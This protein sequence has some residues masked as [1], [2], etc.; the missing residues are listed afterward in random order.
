M[1]DAVGPFTI[2][3][4]VL[5][6]IGIPFS[7][8]PIIVTFKKS[9]VP[10][11]LF[12]IYLSIV[13]TSGCLVVMAIESMVNKE[14]GF[15][16]GKIA[17]IICQMFAFII[18]ISNA[19]TFAL[20]AVERYLTVVKQI[21]LSRKSI[22]KIILGIFVG[23]TCL[24][25]LPS[26][27]TPGVVLPEESQIQCTPAFWLK[28]P[29]ATFIFTLIMI[30]QTVS[31]TVLVYCYYQI[32]NKINQAIKM[33]SAQHAGMQMREKSVV[34]SSYI[35]LI[36]YEYTTGEDVSPV[37]DFITFV[38]VVI[39]FPAT[40]LVTIFLDFRFY[41]LFCE[42]FGIKQRKSADLEPK[43]VH[44]NISRWK[45]TGEVGQCTFDQKP[46]PRKDEKTTALLQ[47]LESIE[48]ALMAVKQDGVIMQKSGAIIQNLSEAFEESSFMI[49]ND[50]RYQKQLEHNEV[51]KAASNASFS[52]N[53]D[54]T[55]N[56]PHL[57]FP[58]S[59]NWELSENL[60]KTMMFHAVFYSKHPN[61]IPGNPVPS[62]YE[63]LAYARRYQYNYEIGALIPNK[64]HSSKQIIADIL[65]LVVEA[66][67][68]FTI[69][70]RPAGI[71]ALNPVIF[72]NRFEKRH[73]TIDDISS[74]PTQEDL[75]SPNS[76]MNDAD[77]AQ[78][79]TVL[80][81]L[82]HVDT[83]NSISSKDAFIL[84]ESLF[85]DNPTWNTNTVPSPPVPIQ[86]NFKDY[87][88][89]SIWENGQFDHMFSE[90]KY[91]SLSEMD[92]PND[93]FS[94]SFFQVRY[95]KLLRKI[96]RF[97]RSINFGNVRENSEKALNLHQEV[98]IFIENHM[99]RS[100]FVF[101]P[102]TG[103][104][105][106]PNVH[107]TGCLDLLSLLHLSAAQINPSLLFSLE[108]NQPCVYTSRDILYAC[109]KRL[110]DMVDQAHSYII[111]G[112]AFSIRMDSGIPSPLFCSTTLSNLTF[113]ISTICLNVFQ[114]PPVDIILLKSVLKIVKD[115]MCPM[116]MQM[117]AVWPVSNRYS[118]YLKDLLQLMETNNQYS[119]QV[120]Q[121]PMT[122]DNNPACTYAAPPLSRFVWTNGRKDDKVD[123]LLEKLDMIEAALIAVKSDDKV[124]EKNGRDIDALCDAFQEAAKIISSSRKNQVVVASQTT[125][126]GL[127]AKYN[128]EIFNPGFNQ[129]RITEGLNDTPSP[130][131]STLTETDIINFQNAFQSSMDTFFTKIPQ[132]TVG[133]E[134]ASH[135]L[136]LSYV[137]FA[138]GNA[139]A[140]AYNDIVVCR[141]MDLSENLKKILMFQAI[142]YSKHPNLIPG[143]PNPTFEDRKMLARQFDYDF[144]ARGT[145]NEI[146]TTM[147][148]IDDIRAI[149]LHAVNMFS[150]QEKNEGMKAMT[151]AFSL[152]KSNKILDASIFQ[153]QFQ[154]NIM[155]IDS[156]TSYRA[157]P[158]VL[159]MTE[160][161]RIQRVS[162]LALF[163][164]LD[165]YSSIATGQGFLLDESLFPEAPI[166]NGKFT[167]YNKF[168]KNK[169]NFALNSIWENTVYDNVFNQMKIDAI[170]KLE[171]AQ[172]SFFTSITQI[173]FIKLMRD[174]IRF[175]RST[176]FNSVQENSEKGVQLHEFILR[177][178]LTITPPVELES[179]MF[180]GSYP[181]RYYPNPHFSPCL[182]LFTLLHFSIAQFNPLLL[183]SLQLGQPCAYT[184]KDIIF[185]CLN[186]QKHVIDMAHFPNILPTPA[187]VGF[188]LNNEI[189]SPLF[190]SST[191][192]NLTFTITSIALSVFQMAPVDLQRLSQVVSMI[193]SS[194]YPAMRRIGMIWP[195]ANDLSR[196]LEGL[197]HIAESSIS[198]NS[199]V[200]CIP[201][202]LL[203]MDKQ[204][205]V[206]S[207]AEF[208]IFRNPAFPE[209]SLRVKYPKLCDPTV[210]QISGY[211]D[212][213][214]DRHVFVFSCKYYFWFFESRDKP[215]SDPVVLWLNGGPGCSSFTG[216]LMEL[217][218]CRVE[219]GGKDTFIHPNSW[220]SN[221]N[222][223]F[224]D[225]PVG[226]GF[227][228]S[229][230]H[231]DSTTEEISQD[232]LV[233]LQTF[234]Y[235]FK[236]YSAL[237]FHITGESYAGHYIPG[238]AKA[239]Y[240]SNKQI[241]AST[242]KKADGY[243]NL[244]SLAIGNGI[245]D[246]IIQYGKYADF[247]EDKKYGPIFSKKT[248]KKMRK[249]YPFCKQL[250]DACYHFQS[251][252]TCVPATQYCNDHITSYFEKTGLNDYDIRLPPGDTTFDDMGHDLN[253]WL[254]NPTIQAELGVNI[255][256]RI[257][258]SDKVGHMFDLQGDE[259]HNLAKDIPTLLEDGIRILIYAGDADWIC[260]WI[261]N[262][263]WT[264]ELEWNGKSEFNEARDIMWKSELTGKKAGEY[265]RFGNFAFLRVYESSHFVPLDQVN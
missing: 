249:A 208:S 80:V 225:Q 11:M 13:N 215:Q 8:L 252:Y 124:M 227:S 2:T 168:R 170:T 241:L 188:E 240:D 102:G 138:G 127:L 181:Q 69:L 79:L 31:I 4:I 156:I 139:N 245:T 214:D 104:T 101:P 54:S 42:H 32:W 10:N 183:F 76:F 94:R 25:A 228:Y 41:S 53:S 78:R 96:I 251:N 100:S 247:G 18:C 191:V 201:N 73:L 134:I 197:I 39:C 196:Q 128:A 37:F 117:G 9:V 143:N 21:T 99:P 256:N 164:N 122:F 167:P 254:N 22:L 233:F 150:I 6:A 132:I 192:C 259:M 265:R 20:I 82:L 157:Q 133:K 47:K 49:K 52:P 40:S 230:S 29:C 226:V 248:V 238:I 59:K 158:P 14:N 74:L 206:S 229:D 105:L 108:A 242:G 173:R 116:F 190:C 92:D 220:N 194:I 112:Q 91:K 106:P 70:D 175:S 211:V 34:K 119:P 60:R 244:V 179:Y 62:F 110:K 28:S 24:A 261:G 209:Y 176:K 180:F 65:A 35:T 16:M 142:F 84:D 257:G 107:M 89:F 161:E 71:R 263:A 137:L 255:K 26:L 103:P 250:I 46:I 120:S 198:A 216:L 186:G 146:L 144:E 85:P 38:C 218:P 51:K 258:C 202:Q 15:A 98:L 3:L 7:A 239:I 185:A 12:P 210:K 237:G 160:N 118:L 174:I 193:N 212:I 109:L 45:K 75:L 64:A 36:L 234:F 207:L 81:S 30:L 219:K 63:K 27:C 155:T 221:A 140:N 217:G 182:A 130:S 177:H 19:Y 204:N 43:A 260:N 77:K 169:S 178:L 86:K 243:V 135:L 149:L 123:S 166:Y 67:N 162:L 205:T 125:P 68:M 199:F 187:A 33:V 126:E 141:S 87:A 90:M 154:S 231:A 224:L 232:V 72:Q 145:K 115:V 223:L 129:R 56:L 203:G 147:Q 61:L 111:D 97:N 165:T 153:N 131:D 184:S 151:I 93:T 195:M 57:D 236:E 83:M 48:Q 264:L 121:Y 222:V 246:P 262:K 114:I 1:A 213:S 55:K 163:L 159:L 58:F 171:I 189:P 88:A 253:V 66:Y 200:Q 152:L 172:E 50:P 5:S 136:E 148:V 113:A 17:C 23:S 95:V 235:A 44:G